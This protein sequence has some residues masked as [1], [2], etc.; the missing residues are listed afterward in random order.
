MVAVAAC[1][2]AAAMVVA[3]IVT[4][5][6]DVADAVDVADVVDAEDVGDVGDVADA[7]DDPDEAEMPHDTFAYVVVLV[8]ELPYVM[9]SVHQRLEL[10]GED[11]QNC[12]GSLHMAYQLLQSNKD[13]QNLYNL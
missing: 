7:V 10:N 13:N 3:R 9:A 1:N 11:A 12:K 5:D 4:D 2:M 6:E 8:V